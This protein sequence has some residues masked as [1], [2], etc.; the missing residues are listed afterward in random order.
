MPFEPGDYRIEVPTA[1]VFQDVDQYIPLMLSALDGWLDF[2][3]RWIDSDPDGLAHLYMEDLR[4]WLQELPLA[5]PPIGSIMLWPDATPPAGWLLCDGDTH[6]PATYPVLSALLG[7][8]FGNVSPYF[9]VPTLTNRFPVGAGD[10][11]S[12]GSTGGA[13]TH[14]LTT[15]QLP[16]HSH[17][18]LAKDNTNNVSN[19]RLA[20]AGGTGTDTTKTTQAAGSGSPHNNMP[21]YQALYY[22]IRAL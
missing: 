3:S 9:R 6:L 2:P 17:D 19:A 11:Y 18:I 21:P 12:V 22:I 15:A 16:A 20:A 1:S 8:T 4:L 10:T 7:E 5:L 14:T 13:A